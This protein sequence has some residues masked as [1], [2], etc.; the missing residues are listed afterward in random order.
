MADKSCM[1][2]R[3]CSVG[4]QIQNPSQEATVLALQIRLTKEEHQS[5]IL[6]GRHWQELFGIPFEPENLLEAFL[7]DF[8]KSS[9]SSGRGAARLIEEWF[10]STDISTPLRRSWI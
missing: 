1:A 2:M 7:A 4:R 9:R 5:L 8:T 10:L 3:K 6:L